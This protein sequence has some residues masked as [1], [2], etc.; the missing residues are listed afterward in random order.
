MTKP[1]AMTFQAGKDSSRKKVDA[2][3]P[4]MGTNK[5]AGATTAA[6]CLDSSQPQ[7]AYPN[8]VLPQDC[9]NTAIQAPMGADR[10]TSHK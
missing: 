8:K 4:K 6:G 1:A 10:V 5:G 2:P 7:A 3:I 9:Q